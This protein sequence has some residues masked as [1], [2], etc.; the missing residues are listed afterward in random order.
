MVIYTWFIL[1]LQFAWNIR[2]MAI[3]CTAIMMYNDNGGYGFGDEI[4]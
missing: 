3:W 1:L 2:F 4:Q